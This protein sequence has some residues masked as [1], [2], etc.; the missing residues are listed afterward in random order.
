M[1]LYNKLLCLGLLVFAVSCGN[2]FDVE[3]NFDLESL[4]GYVA[5]FADGNSINV[6]AQDLAEAGGSV[7]VVVHSPV[8]ILSDAT[9]NYSLGG[10]AVLGTDYTIEGASGTSGTMTIS[11]DRGNFSETYR[12]SITIVALDNAVF[13]GDKTIE[14]TLTS[15]S[16]AEGDIAVGRGGTDFQKVA[17]VNLI[18]DECE[19]EYAGSYRA[20]ASV[21]SVV[22][23]GVLEGSMLMGDTTDVTIEKLAG[24][25]F[26]YNV[27]D[28]SAGVYAAVFSGTALSYDVVEDCGAISAEGQVDEFGQTINLVSGGVGADG[29]ITLTLKEAL[30]GLQWTT[31]FLPN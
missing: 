21:D 8:E 20:V 27:S 7:D 5:F 25:Y 12:G 14:L 9:V 11:S 1:R 16:N 13:E 15:A 4:P 19:S 28:A 18:D 26:A 29:V 2:E 10:T 17:V 22:V 24:E 30:T 31:V 3:E 23:N 6:A